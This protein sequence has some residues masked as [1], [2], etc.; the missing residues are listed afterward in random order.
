MTANGDIES[1]NTLSISDKRKVLIRLVPEDRQDDVAAMLDQWF[2]A[3]ASDN[4]EIKEAVIIMWH[5]I[6]PTLKASNMEEL[7]SQ[8]QEYYPELK[9]S[10]VE[11]FRSLSLMFEA[12]ALAREW[13]TLS[14]FMD[15][16]NFDSEPGSRE[17]FIN[18]LGAMFIL[19]DDNR[20][21]AAK[22]YA[23]YRV[24]IALWTGKNVPG[25]IKLFNRM[26]NNYD[27]DVNAPEFLQYIQGIIDTNNKK[28]WDII[29]A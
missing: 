11:E 26:F 12:S 3:L 21:E 18:R 14:D 27:V 9:P 22:A 15:L 29:A 19:A 5:T 8:M 28:V 4:Q 10:P 2:L 1:N 24:G 23:V 17:E 13:E 6:V 7:V 25:M 16:I 20:T